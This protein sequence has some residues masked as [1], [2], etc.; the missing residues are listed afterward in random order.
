MRDILAEFR[1]GAAADRPILVGAFVVWA[2]FL[3][4]LAVKGVNGFWPLLY[5]S[6]FLIYLSTLAFFLTYVVGRI[7]W[8]DRP[9]RPIAHLR[10]LLVEDASARHFVRGAPMFIAL[11]V[12]MPAFSE[13]KSA[14]PL[15]HAYT[16][17]HVWIAADRSLHGADPWR[18][19]QP[20]L[21]Y[22]AVTAL[23][24]AAYHRWILLIYA[25]GL[26]FCFLQRDATLRAQYFI[27]FFAIWVVLGVVLATAL[28]SVGPAFVG[29]LLGNH[30]FDQQ[31][32]YL[33][34]ANE[35]FPIM[36][37]AV[38]GELLQSYHN[39]NHGLGRGLSAMP[40]LHV[41]MAFLFFL[42]M[43][44]VS[45]GAGVAFGV[46]VVVVML[47]SVHLAYH[48][49]VDGYVSIALTSVIWLAA[50]VPARL[51]TGPSRSELALPVF[52]P[53]SRS[54]NLPAANQMT[55]TPAPPTMPSE[56]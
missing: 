49:A 51:M 47:G 52:P 17:D 5:F 39:A 55:A 37:L 34:S 9:E 42:A 22:P 11:I 33:R 4:L 45:R 26:Y 32:A 28:A 40:S 29:P 41:A 19:L 7:L 2:T 13:M 24:A 50:G 44:R 30:H 18:I 36:V 15:F 1:R 14:I 10:D 16:W 56:A 20:V 43:R 53:S 25:G 12:F 54:E 38:Q 27:G 21:G 6:N 35:H 48:Y 23:I 31:M 8:R 3:A 46:F